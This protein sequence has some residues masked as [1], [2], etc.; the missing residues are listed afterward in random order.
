MPAIAGN[1]QTHHFDVNTINACFRQAGQHYSVHP[2]ILW[3]IAKVE[4]N[5][6]PFAINKNTN[7]TFDIGIM[8]INSS[9]I[10]V[11]K[12]HGLKHESMLWD[13][14]YNIYVGAWVLSQCIAKHGYTWEAIGCYN[15]VSSTKRVKYANKVYKALEPY[16]RDQ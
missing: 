11:L 8:Q 14:C 1:Y 6:N 13:P 12:R 9:W 7:G 2:N 15:A 5:F 4:S 10:S 16:I 3:A